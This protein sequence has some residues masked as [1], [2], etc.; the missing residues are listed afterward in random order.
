MTQVYAERWAKEH[1][2]HAGCRAEFLG[3]QVCDQR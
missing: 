3:T 2:T 1:C